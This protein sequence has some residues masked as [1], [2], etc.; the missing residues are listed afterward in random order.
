MLYGVIALLE[1][2][3]RIHEIVL[4]APRA[5][6]RRPRPRSSPA[7]SSISASCRA[8]RDNPGLVGN[9]RA[10]LAFPSIPSATIR[11]PRPMPAFA[12]GVRPPRRDHVTS[13]AG[14]PA[15]H[16]TRSPRISLSAIA[17]PA[18]S[19]PLRQLK[20][21]ASFRPRFL[22]RH[23][24]RRRSMAR[25]T[26]CPSISPIR[27]CPPHGGPEHLFI[28]YRL[29]VTTMLDV[30]STLFDVTSSQQSSAFEQIGIMA[31][32]R[33]RAASCLP[34]GL[35]QLPPA[36][37]TRSICP[38]SLPDPSLRSHHPCDRTRLSQHPRAQQACSFP[39]VED[40]DERQISSSRTPPLPIAAPSMDVACAGA[41]IS[42]LEQISRARPPCS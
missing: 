41:Q 1:G 39:S 16:A 38:R 42:T 14:S 22:R 8:P 29:H 11:L 13:L 9:R 19:L 23:L 24:Q 27:A 6:A 32:C 17:T 7:P 25:S 12:V 31:F 10:T 20:P 35:A 30:L 36:R 28:I 40:D 15:K 34:R 33:R 4:Q 2:P 18:S 26:A 37:R 21:P 5:S 3:S